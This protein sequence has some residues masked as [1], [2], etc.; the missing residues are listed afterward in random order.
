MK[1]VLLTLALVISAAYGASAQERVPKWSYYFAN[2]PE[3]SGLSFYV[4]QI[5]RPITVIV[6]ARVAGKTVSETREFPASSNARLFRMAI[7]ADTD[8]VL[9]VDIVMGELSDS[10]KLPQSGVVYSFSTRGVQ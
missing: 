6:H 10:R 5:G 9:S 7:N 1:T 8:L 3:G 4:D 2:G